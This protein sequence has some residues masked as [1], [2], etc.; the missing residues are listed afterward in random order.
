MALLAILGLL[1]IAYYFIYVVSCVFMDSDLL[2]AFKEKFGKPVS[3][4]KGKTVWITGASTGIGETLAYVLAKNGCKLILSARRT[5]ELE[6]VKRKCLEEN[7]LLSDE[8]IE[9]YPMD[10]LNLHLHKEALQHVI[11]KFGKLDILVNNAG[12][13]QRAK[14]ENIDIMVDKEMF[15]LNVFSILSLSRLAIKHFLQ[16]GGGH[17]VVNSSL[18][19]IQA[20]PMSASYCGAKHALHG[21]FKPFCL[22][23]YDKSIDVTMV[24]PGPVQTGF[25]SNCFTEE[26]GKKYGVETEI[27]KDKISA[28]RCATLMGIA[29]ANKL[30]EVWIAQ[31]KVML[32][33][34]LSYCFPNVMRWVLRNIGAKVLMKLRDSKKD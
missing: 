11:N 30:E 28:E 12:R 15:E 1:I 14:W 25:L 6:R 13:S 5:T 21:Y 32:I 22:E 19:G 18:A 29:I 26:P 7:K 33:V 23:Y 4:L 34:Y 16:T 20:I 8:D 10:I 24:C 9:V 2:L 31:P 3:S 27:S 17:I